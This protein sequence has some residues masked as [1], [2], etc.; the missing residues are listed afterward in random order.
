MKS[1]GQL[2]QKVVWRY[3]GEI[4]PQLPLNIFMS[5]CLPKNEEILAHKNIVLFI[6]DGETANCQIAA[7]RNIPLLLIPFCSDQVIKQ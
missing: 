2:K 4:V 3:G 7:T 1:F 6:T 5:N